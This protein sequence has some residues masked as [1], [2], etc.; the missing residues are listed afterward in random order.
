MFDTMIRRH[1]NICKVEFT[2]DVGIRLK[3][4][5]REHFKNNATRMSL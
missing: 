1:G 3:T 5:V 2:V 4:M